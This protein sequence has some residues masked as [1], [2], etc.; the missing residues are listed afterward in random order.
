VTNEP[1]PIDPADECLDEFEERLDEGDLAGARDAL[2]RAEAL[3]GSDDPEVRL[4]AIELAFE[5]EGPERAR[6][7]T[8]A[9]VADEPDYPDAWYA[10]GRIRA[11]TGDEPGAI[12]C[13]VRVSRLDAELDRAF[14]PVEPAVL[15]R[16]ERVAREVVEGLPPEFGRPL[17]NVPIVLEERPSLHIVREGFDP[18][19]FGL[20]EGN[21]EGADHHAVPTRIVL[22]TSSLVAAFGEGAELDEQVE[23]TVLHEIG[24]FFHLD[25]DGVARLGLA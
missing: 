12:D 3:A 14:P 19:S 7:L 4:A 10:L 15:A 21:E 22:Y 5:A 1:D 17:T 6:A 8:D 11:E 18:R 23:I 2:S 16:I 25:E 24:H 9:L 13:F 20:F